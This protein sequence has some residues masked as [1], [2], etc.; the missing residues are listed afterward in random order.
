MGSVCNLAGENQQQPF[1][2]LGYALTPVGGPAL[3]CSAGTNFLRLFSI[4]TPAH[5]SDG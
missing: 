1:F 2:S 3:G 4:L 5:L